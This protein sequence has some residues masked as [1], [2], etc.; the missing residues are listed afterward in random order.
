MNQGFVQ[1]QKQQQNL[2]IT[3]ELQQSLKIL[4]LPIEALREEIYKAYEENPL[5]EICENESTDLQKEIDDYLYSRVDF[6][7]RNNPD[8][9]FDP[10]QLKAKEKSLKEELYE[11][12]A[13]YRLNESMSAVMSFIIESLDH[14][15][16]MTEDLA[17][18]ASLVGT[19]IS[20]VEKGLELI[21]GLSPSGIG[22]R[23]F[24]ECISIQINQMTDVELAMKLDMNLMVC[25]YLEQIGQLNFR[26]ISEKMG[27]EEERVRECIRVI[28]LL[29]PYPSSGYNTNDEIRYVIPEAIVEVVN[30]NINVIMNDINLPRLIVNEQYK[31]MLKKTSDDET[32]TYIRNRINKSTYLINSIDFREK[33]I[34]DVIL[35]IVMR[36]I[37]FF[38][39]DS[40]ELQP[41]LIKDIAEDLKLNE[42]TVS[43]AIKDKYIL[44]TNRTILMKSLFS[45]GINRVDT[46]ETISS[47][48]VKKKIKSMIENENSN[49]PLSDEQLSRLLR[50]NGIDISRRTVAK[51]RM[52][53]GI[54]GSGLRK[55]KALIE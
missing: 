20:E 42:S 33:T 25:N 8:V 16:Y 13:I 36:Q 22:A 48:G 41:M 7:R 9:S 27:I 30:G 53:M 6:A 54:D 45:T 55:R 3:Q 11:Q 51:Y 1:Q 47:D 2:S 50:K 32:K 23:N 18:I 40:K 43:R 17:L 21:Q 29:N 39:G 15:G 19:D 5:L 52:L 26:V 4:Q 44:N 24:Q 35:A 28:K 46:D 34:H 37:P 38:T 12:L 10:L 14:R 49:N 31:E